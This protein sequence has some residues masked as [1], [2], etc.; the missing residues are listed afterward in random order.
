MIVWYGLVQYGM[1]LD[2]PWNMP[3]NFCFHVQAEKSCFDKVWY[4][5]AWYAMVLDNPWD[6]PSNFSFHVQA[7]I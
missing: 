3:S 1:V 4:G 7:Q 2:N 6:M 5:L